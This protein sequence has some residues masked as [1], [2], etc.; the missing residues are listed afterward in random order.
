LTKEEGVHTL[1]VD[2]DAV[3]KI[4]EDLQSGT[5]ARAERL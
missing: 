2:G 1:E 5:A 3:K 4:E